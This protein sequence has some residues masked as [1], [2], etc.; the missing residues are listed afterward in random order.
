MVCDLW[1]P[2]LLVD[3]VTEGRRLFLAAYVEKVKRVSFPFLNV[4]F[5]VIRK[6]KFIVS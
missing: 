3:I 5:V 6:I 2:P 4:S 1:A